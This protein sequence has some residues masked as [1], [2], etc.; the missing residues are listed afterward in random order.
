MPV[1]ISF[2]DSNL[3]RK[4]NLGVRDHK[5]QKNGM[6]MTLIGA[7]NTADTERASAVRSLD[8]THIIDMDG[9][10]AGMDTRRGEFVELQ[11]GDKIIIKIWC[12]GVVFFYK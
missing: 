6:G 7:F 2:G 9:Q 8:G 12:N 5:R 11:A 10:T 4:G 1:F 3:I